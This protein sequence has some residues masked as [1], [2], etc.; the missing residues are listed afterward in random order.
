[1]NANMT[2]TY[3]FK[4]DVRG[5]RGAVVLTGGAPGLCLDG[6]DQVGVGLVSAVAHHLVRLPC[7]NRH[8]LLEGLPGG[9]L[10]Q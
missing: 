10:F 6:A 8:Y 4:D 7:D 2:L 1:M 5:A 3:S 9:S